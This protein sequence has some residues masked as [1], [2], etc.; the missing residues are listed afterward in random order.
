MTEELCQ[1]C[2]ERE[3]DAEGMLCGQCIAELNQMD[4]ELERYV[5]EQERLRENH[6]GE[7]CWLTGKLLCQEGFCSG[8]QVYLD[9]K[10]SLGK[11][12]IE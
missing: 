12:S 1:R 10:E 8:C 5:F 11:V 2:G 7:W 9:W 6:K 4:F 3:V